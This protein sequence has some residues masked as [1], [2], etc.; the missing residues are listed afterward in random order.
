MS[1]IERCPHDKKNPYAIIN[2]DL[3]RDQSLSP[4]CRWLLIYLLSMS[5]GWKISAKQIHAHV[6]SFMGR[7]KVWDL[8]K[9]AIVAGYMRREC[10]K[11]GTRF[12][13]VTYYLS[14]YP[15]FKEVTE[16][17]NNVYHAPVLGALKTTALKT[18]EDKKDQ[19]PKE[20]SI[21]KNIFIVPPVVE[22][23]KNDS[24]EIEKEALEISQELWDRIKQT[25]PTHKPPNLKDWA[26]TV[27][28]AH[29]ID[30]RSWDD[31]RAVLKFSFEKNDF[32]SRTLQSAEGLRKHFDKI[33]AQMRP[34]TTPDAGIEEN[35]KI[36]QE[37]KQV[38]VRRNE[39]HLLI[40]HK[41]C[42]M[43]QDGDSISF[44]L[45]KETFEGILI[46][47]FRLRKTDG[48]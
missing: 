37:I 28:K 26:K 45:P 5:D 43:F 20:G 30:H 24:L 9:E 25:H 14:E 33:W 47:R 34:P 19:E 46:K 17:S 35:L 10:V 40:L 44:A 32:W 29:R 3:I 1:N 31:L 15:K 48:V 6:K 39:G 27:S 36:A 41:N 38:L 4:N 23:S 18:G 42:V 21:E 2:T 22:T 11:E 16:N 13:G 8:L 7:K 12:S